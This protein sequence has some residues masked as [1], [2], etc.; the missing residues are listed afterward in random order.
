MP[1]GGTVT[2]DDFESGQGSAACGGTTCHVDFCI[3]GAGSDVRR[4]ARGLAREGERQDADRLRLPHRRHRPRERGAARGARDA[5][6][7]GHHLVQALHGVQERPSGRRR[8]AVPGDGGRR[9]ERRARH[10]A[11]RERGR[12]RRPRARGARARR[13]GA[14]PPRAHAAA[15]ARGRGDEPRDPARADRRLPALRRPRHLPG[16]GRADP[17]RTRAGLGRLGRDVHAVLLPVDRRPRPA[18][19][20]GR[21]VRLLA[22]RA[23]RREPRRPV[24]RGAHRRALGDLDRPLRLPLGRAEDARRGRLHED[25]ERRPGPR[26]PARR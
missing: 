19:L 4:G 17:P 6:G 7:A 5:A 8:D 22:A 9:G 11:C 25:P 15:G 14:D 26:G 16:G 18:G 10:G 23:R 13:H 12:D 2:I 21:E 1:F 3:Q 24:G 20:R